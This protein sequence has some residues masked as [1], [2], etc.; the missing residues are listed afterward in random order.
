MIRV[1]DTAGNHHSVPGDGDFHTED[2]T[3]NLV[4]E[5]DRSYVVFA[6]GQWVMAEKVLHRGE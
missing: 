4:V 6:E 1:I 3:N 5:T 2:V